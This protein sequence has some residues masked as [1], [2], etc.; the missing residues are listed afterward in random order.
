MAVINP[1]DN[2]INESQVDGTELARRLERLYAVVHSQNSSQTRPPAV[3][4]GGLWSKP[5]TGG[6]DVMLFDGTNDVK[7]G[8][9]VNGTVPPVGLL[10]ADAGN[11]SRLGSDQK[12]YTPTPTAPD[13]S[14]Y[15]TAAT[16]DAKYV[17]IGGDA[18]TGNLSA[19]QITASTALN[20]NTS[21]YRV[22]PAIATGAGHFTVASHATQ[23]RMM[24][25]SGYIPAGGQGNVPITFPIAFSNTPALYSLMDGTPGD[26]SLLT[27]HVYGGSPTGAT[28]GR[29]YSVNGGSVG[30]ANQGFIWLAFG[31]V[32]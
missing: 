27:M 13:L 29:R 21:D 17:N 10:S 5:V 26:D 24:L 32:S 7:I 31:Q 6:F 14:A 28:F 25:Q 19:V 1:G 8:S 18:M 22:V 20:V 3:T 23:H 9:V 15:E 30:P 12:V 4:E 2:T 11:Y 16:A